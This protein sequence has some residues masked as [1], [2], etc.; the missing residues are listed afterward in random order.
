MRLLE[1]IKKVVF[2]IEEFIGFS[3]S[4]KLHLLIQET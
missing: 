4:L 3:M 1:E 2:V